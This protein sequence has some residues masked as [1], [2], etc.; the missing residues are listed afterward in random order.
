[1]RRT[2]QIKSYD[3]KIYGYEIAFAIIGLIKIPVLAAY[4]TVAN[5]WL[6]VGYFLTFI[7]VIA[8]IFDYC[9]GIV[10]AKLCKSVFSAI[11]SFLAFYIVFIIVGTLLLLLVTGG[12]DFQACAD[13]CN[14]ASF[15]QGVLT[16]IAI[17]SAPMAVVL[18][19]VIINATKK[20]KFMTSKKEMFNSV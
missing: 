9:L 19:S 1:M 8:I 18:I 6:L 20:K 5:G 4:F 14:N 17:M 12:N 7:W 13:V 3:S 16:M 15:L 11:M 10:I 2:R